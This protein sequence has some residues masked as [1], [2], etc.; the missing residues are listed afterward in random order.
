MNLEEIYSIEEIKKLKARYCRYFDT[1]RWNDLFALFTDDA[2][3]DMRSAGSVESAD[4]AGGAP[5]LQSYKVG[6]DNIAAHLA[7]VVADISSSVHFCH[8]PEITI[9]SP[10]AA[11]GIWA[12]D[13]WHQFH[14]GPLKSF[15]GFGHY[16]DA[17]V[18]ENGAWRIKSTRLTRVRVDIEM[19]DAD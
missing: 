5:E 18:R 12:L 9:T 2:I 14:S 4:E 8:A 1:N 7:V 15:H 10:D 16:E 17:Y 13:D 6:R 19:A 3:F 11:T